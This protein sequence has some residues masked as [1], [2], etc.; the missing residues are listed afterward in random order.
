MQKNQKNKTTLSKVLGRTDIIAIGFGT[1]VGWSWVMLATSWIDTAGFL[2][3][4][5]A[6]CLGGLIIFFIGLVYGELTSALPLAGGEFVFVYRAMGRKTACFVGWIMAFAYLSVAA[7]ESI[8]FATAVNYIFPIPPEIPLFEISGYQVYLSW[9]LVGAIGAAIIMCLN[10]FGVRPAVLF[11]VLATAALMITV[12]VLLLGGVAFG[13]T[14]NIGKMFSRPEG[15]FAVLSIVPAMML[16]FDIIP[17]SAE[18]MNVAPREIG[19]MI[20]VCIVISLV[21]YLIV[22]IAI[23]LAAPIEVRTSGIIPTADVAA[24]L[25]SS[26][27]FSVIIV[28][29]GILGILTSWNGFFMA[30]TRLIFAMGRANVLPA[31]FKN[32]HHKYRTPWAATLLVGSCCILAPFLGRDAL[33]WF[34][35]TSSLCA[36]VSYCF[37]GMSFINLRRKE[38]HLERPFYIKGGAPFG[39]VTLVITA[40]YVISYIINNF[41]VEKS[42]VELIILLG[43]IVLGTVLI[44]ATEQRRKAESHYEQEVAVFG[45]KFARRK[46]YHEK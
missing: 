4:L 22:I 7:W 17:Q 13:E 5:L 21:W 46:N 39:I 36:L 35:N 3:A 37:V 18:E 32:V 11:Q 8:A 42:G 31:V 19:R 43:W 12:I 2:G 26:D 33:I 23:A 15:F 20:V 1:I 10:L 40:V 25:F 9:A 44:S 27:I 24:Y 41:I 34:V 16:G 28:F 38:P 6:F 29:S 45:E 14:G 30:S